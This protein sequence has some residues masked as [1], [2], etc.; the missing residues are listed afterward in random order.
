MNEFTISTMCMYF[1]FGN[2]KFVKRG[3]VTSLCDTSKCYTMSPYKH[4]LF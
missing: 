1:F 3:N 2:L 4:K